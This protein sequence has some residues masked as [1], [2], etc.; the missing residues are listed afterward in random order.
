MSEVEKSVIRI[1]GANKTRDYAI[2]FNVCSQQ[3]Q[4]MIVGEYEER[5]IGDRIDNLID[6]NDYYDKGYADAYKLFKELANNET[7]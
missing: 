1:K 5:H 6:L 7:L 4:M 2:G 3:I